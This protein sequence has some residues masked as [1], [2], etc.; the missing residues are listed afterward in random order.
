MNL[1]MILSVIINV[2][3]IALLAGI[4]YFLYKILAVLKDH[5]IFYDNMRGE[6][7]ETNKK[8]DDV[9]SFLKLTFNKDFAKKVEDVINIKE[10]IPQ[11]VRR[12]CDDGEYHEVPID[13]GW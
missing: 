11:T 6:Y 10:N 1:I 2:S 13:H 4:A 3:V 9:L 5:W 12:M 7:E 8:M